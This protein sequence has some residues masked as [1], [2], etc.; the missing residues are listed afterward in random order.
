MGATVIAP[1]TGS[2][3]GPD[4]AGLAIGWTTPTAGFYSDPCQ[5]APHLTPQILPGPSVADFV[6]AAVAHPLLGIDGAVDVEVGG[7]RGSY[8]ELRAPDDISGCRDWRPFDPGIAAQGP[9]NLWKVWALDVEGLRM[10][11]LIE[12]FP[13]TPVEVA[14]ELDAMVESIQFLA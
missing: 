3:E 8:F 6:D 10:V 4:G 9:N 13:D 14:A 7:Y 1:A 2:T 5:P 11:V 12:Q